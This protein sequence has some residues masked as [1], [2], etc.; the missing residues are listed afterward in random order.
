MDCPNCDTVLIGSFANKHWGN[1]DDYYCS[2]CG[3]FWTR[4]GK[5]LTPTKLHRRICTSLPVVYSKPNFF[6]EW[7]PEMAWVLGLVYS[8][9]SVSTQRLSFGWKEP[10]LCHKVARLLGPPDSM[11][12]YLQHR[13]FP[14]YTITYSHPR[15]RLSL[16]AL[17]VPCGK[18][19]HIMQFPKVPYPL[20]RHFVRGYF[21]GDGCV[22][23]CNEGRQLVVAF[24]SASKPFL[25]D[26]VAHLHEFEMSLR[27]VYT[28]TKSPSTLPQG[29]LIKERIAHEVK[30]CKQ[31]DVQQFYHLVYN[32]VD[33]SIYYEPKHE[34]FE[35]HPTF[36]SP[37]M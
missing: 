23:T 36:N 11:R 24:S 27:P 7:S 4:Y 1:M 19:S 21:D 25:E 8:D 9:G 35:S 13:K 2:Q 30:Y 3:N 37:A 33:A 32:N 6:C 18:K 14:I 28:Y 16:T 22:T 17:G 10:E 26:L 31:D 29:G 12:N 5:S 20:A 15:L 34:R